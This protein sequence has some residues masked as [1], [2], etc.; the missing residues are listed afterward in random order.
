MLPH[1][2]LESE[3]IKSFHINVKLLSWLEQSIQST[4]QVDL[5]PLGASNTHQTN[6]SKSV[7]IIN[8]LKMVEN[9][10]LPCLIPRYALSDMVLWRQFQNKHNLKITKKSLCVHVFLNLR[11]S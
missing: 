4:Y 9:V 10:F 6:L 11:A 7:Q 3:I 1:F 8:C 5:D 2:H